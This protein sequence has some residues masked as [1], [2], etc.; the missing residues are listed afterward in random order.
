MLKLR[1]HRFGNQLPDQIYYSI[2]CSTSI[3]T[4]QKNI[5]LRLNN[6]NLP[7]IFNEILIWYSLCI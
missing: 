4:Q 7:E 2:Y 3:N 1:I 5:Y 6:N